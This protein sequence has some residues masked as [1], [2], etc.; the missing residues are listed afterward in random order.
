MEEMVKEAKYKN[1]E[2]VL[3]IKSSIL[4]DI[5]DVN[6]EYRMYCL[7]LRQLSPI[8][9]GVQSA[10][11][12]VEY[13]NKY[14][15]DIE[16]MAWS[17]VDKTI[18]MLDGGVLDDLENIIQQLCDNGV[19]YSFFKEEDLGNI[20][21][22]I[23]LIADERVFNK[24]KY[25][26]FRIWRD[27]KYPNRMSHLIAVNNT[28]IEMECNDFIPDLINDFTYT[29]HYE[30]WLHDVIGGKRNEFLRNLLNSKRLSH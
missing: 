28:D 26:D 15:T 9:K 6:M 21:T 10:H 29:E 3:K 2:I 12:I 17:R 23:S 25:P 13:A 11:S 16:Y 8:Q 24:K 22:A 7:V 30:E 4:P 27:M 18:V 1:G 20:T 19:K 14:C 5:T